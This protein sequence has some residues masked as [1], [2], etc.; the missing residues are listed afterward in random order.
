MLER[1][2]SSYIAKSIFLNVNER[3]KLKIIKYNKTNNNINEI[4]NGKGYIISYYS[5]SDKLYFE[6]E[7]I[8]GKINGNG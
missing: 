2:K 5:G 1:I 6:G 3:L 8:N 7:F 4:K